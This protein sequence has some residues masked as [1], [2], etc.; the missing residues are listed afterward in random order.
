MM[1]DE[2]LAD[3]LEKL[4]NPELRDSQKLLLGYPRASAREARKLQPPPRESAVAF[5]VYRREGVW[6]TA[7]MKRP[8]DQGVHSNQ[9]SF[10]GGKLE[11]G[12][13]A[14][15]AAIRETFEEIGVLPENIRIIGELSD[16]FIPPSHFVVQ[17]F[18]AHILDNPSFNI[19]PGEVSELIE[20]PLSDLLSPDLIRE[21]ELYLPY[22]KTRMKVKCFDIRGHVLWGATAMMVQEFRS[23]YGFHS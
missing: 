6:T 17:P 9:I 11:S 8:G 18:I 21:E 13:S 3:L 14:M 15:Q 10:P 23:L 12:E 2:F 1:E 22:F 4:N 19:N 20:Y 16:L 5:P 7:F